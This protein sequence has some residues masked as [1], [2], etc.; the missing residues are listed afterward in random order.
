MSASAVVAEDFPL[1][2]GGT[3]LCLAAYSA[4]LFP[5]SSFQECLFEVRHDF[6]LTWG[7]PS[8]CLFT[9]GAADVRTTGDSAVERG[10]LVAEEF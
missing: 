9:S 8:F 6:R 2:A 4:F 7:L 3:D 10:A 5:L 1:F